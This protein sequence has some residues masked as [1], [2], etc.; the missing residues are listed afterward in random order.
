MV[1]VPPEF[2]L[3][4]VKV[5]AC[6]APVMVKFTDPLVPDKVLTTMPNVPGSAGSVRAAV[7]CVVL[8]TMTL[9]TV[10]AGLLAV[11]TVPP[12]SSKKFVPV[13]VTLT[14]LPA[15]PE[16]GLI[17]NNTGGPDPNSTILWFG[18]ATNRFVPEEDGRG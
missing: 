15:A 10:T 8:G 12:G 6:V 17:A 1:P 3:T 11:T 14:V 9:L 13:K 4:E 5:G 2:G 16:F 7:A 18:D